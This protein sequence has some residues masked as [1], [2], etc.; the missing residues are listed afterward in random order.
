MVMGAPA[1]A[2]VLE[3]LQ[4]AGCRR[5]VYW[6]PSAGRSGV[7]RALERWGSA[8]AEFTGEA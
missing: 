5:A 8:I 3:E 1:N 6:V 4:G 7:E 2:A